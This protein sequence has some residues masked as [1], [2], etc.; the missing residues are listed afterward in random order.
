MKRFCTFLFISIFAVYF[1]SSLT[2]STPRYGNDSQNPWGLSA[3]IQV[4]YRD[5]NPNGQGR[6]S[7][8]ITIQLRSINTTINYDYLLQFKLPTNDV[9]FE[10]G[11]VH[12]GSLPLGKENGSTWYTFRPKSPSV[13]LIR[14]N[15]RAS[16][17][18]VVGSTPFGSEVP[19]APSTIA[20]SLF[21][22]GMMQNQKNVSRFY[23]D[24]QR[25]VIEPLPSLPSA[26][27]LERIG[28]AV[29]LEDAR[30]AKVSD[31]TL[32]LNVILP[33]VFGSAFLIV[34]SV[35]L[36]RW[37]QRRRRAYQTVEETV[38]HQ[39]RHMAEEESLGPSYG[40]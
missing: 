26:V 4:E 19:L 25:T 15:E 39:R 1:Q 32:I 33:I 13:G 6:S 5:T 9:A 35:F 14:S 38:Q 18:V 40:L 28:S 30:S 22:D 10:S 27:F 37:W 17:L 24:V 20:V 11:N 3:T 21:P 29:A 8:G 31:K 12:L 34:G 7:F 2:Q 23:L 36:W 16:T